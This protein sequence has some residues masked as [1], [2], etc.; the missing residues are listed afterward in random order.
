MQP[1]KL[2]ADY[3]VE[4]VGVGRNAAETIMDTQHVIPALVAAKAIICK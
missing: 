2:I 4:F 1:D 3:A